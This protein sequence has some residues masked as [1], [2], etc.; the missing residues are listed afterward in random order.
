[1]DSDAKSPSLSPTF[2]LGERE[3][4]GEREGYLFFAKQDEPG[5]RVAADVPG[6]FF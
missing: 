5:V 3:K 4:V 1:L 2:S 6:D